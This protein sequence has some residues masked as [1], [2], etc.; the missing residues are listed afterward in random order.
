MVAVFLSAM[1]LEVFTVYVLVKFFAYDL[2]WE[3]LSQFEMFIWNLLLVFPKFL[4]IY[5]AAET[6]GKAQDLNDLVE[7]Y[8]NHCNDDIF[9]DVRKKILNKFNNIF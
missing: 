9:Q 5:I 7:K 3:P 6:T 8:S 2:R 4:G 1:V